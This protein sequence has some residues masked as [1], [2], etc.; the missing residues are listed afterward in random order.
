MSA[1]TFMG[2]PVIVSELVPKDKVYVT[3]SYIAAGTM[4]ILRELE[5]LVAS[6]T[7]PGL[8]ASP[9]VTFDMQLTEAGVEFR[10]H[11]FEDYSRRREVKDPI[12]P[13][14]ERKVLI[15]R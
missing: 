7:M 9:E 4:T 14:P 1:V 6:R 12:P 13:V 5:D 10:D 8:Q 2:T 11:L 15:R 3:P